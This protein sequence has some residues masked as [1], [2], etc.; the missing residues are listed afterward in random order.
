MNPVCARA[1]RR[2]SS[3]LGVLLPLPFPAAAD[4][5]P[6][7]AAVPAAG[8]GLDWFV[9]GA[10]AAGAGLVILLGAWALLAPGRDEGED[11]RTDS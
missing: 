3:G 8:S 10:L 7:A 2:A 4:H 1:G 5:G 9:L 6:A 11:D